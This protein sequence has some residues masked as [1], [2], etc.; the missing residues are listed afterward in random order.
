MAAP[1]SPQGNMLALLSTCKIMCQEDYETLLQASRISLS[2]MAHRSSFAIVSP[3]TLQRQEYYLKKDIIARS[4][5]ISFQSMT[6]KVID[7]C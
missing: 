5:N 1:A 2:T 7:R 3:T 6:V 4:G